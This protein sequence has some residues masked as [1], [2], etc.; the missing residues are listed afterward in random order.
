MIINYEI[1]LKN[2][3][4]L[5]AMNKGDNIFIGQYLFTGNETTSVWLEVLQYLRA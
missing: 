3:V 4:L 5:Q 2:G 1:F